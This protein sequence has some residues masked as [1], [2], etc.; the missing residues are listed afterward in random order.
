G[1]PRLVTRSGQGS[2][3]HD[4]P[5]HYGAWY[6]SRAAVSAIAETIQR[7]RGQI[8]DDRYFTRHHVLTRSIVALDIDERVRVLDLDD[9]AEL[10]ARKIRPSQVATFRRDVTQRMALSVFQEGATGISWWST[11][12]AAWTN[13]TLFQ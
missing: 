10:I 3:R 13:V 8:L 11:L 6:C 7:L 1:G 9:P 12:E 2:G 4:A 5:P